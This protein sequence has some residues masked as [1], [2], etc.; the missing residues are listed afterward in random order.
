MHVAEDF[1]VE[2]DLALDFREGEVV[3]IAVSR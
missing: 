1:A 2:S 3:A